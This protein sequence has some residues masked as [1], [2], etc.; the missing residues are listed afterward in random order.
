MWKMFSPHVLL[1]AP[2]AQLE[3]VQLLLTSFPS[4]PRIWGGVTSAAADSKPQPM[5]SKSTTP[6][7]ASKGEKQRNNSEHKSADGAVS[8]SAVKNALSA[9]TS[10]FGCAPTT[11]FG[12]LLQLMV[13]HR[14]QAAS[15]SSDQSV[16]SNLSSSLHSF[17]ARV[18]RTSGVFAADV[19]CMLSKDADSSTL[20]DTVITTWLRH[21][22]LFAV[23]FVEKV[24]TSRLK[25]LT[26]A[27]QRATDATAEGKAFPLLMFSFQIVTTG[28]APVAPITAS[29]AGLSN[30]MDQAVQHLLV[31]VSSDLAWLSSPS[32]ASTLLASVGVALDELISTREAS[33]SAVAP[34]NDRYA[35]LRD[36]TAAAGAGTV[37]GNQ[38]SFEQRLKAL[39]D[40]TAD[41]SPVAA[42][43]ARKSDKAVSVPA[44]PVNSVAV[45]D[46]GSY[47]GIVD[48][49]KQ[50]QQTCTLVQAVLDAV[51]AVLLSIGNT[52]DSPVQFAKLWSAVQAQSRPATT[53][54]LSSAAL[55]YSN[56]RG[57]S[58][59]LKSM[60]L[61]A[62]SVAANPAAAATLKRK[63]P[64]ESGGPSHDAA[65]EEAF[66]HLPLPAIL[67]LLFG[68]PSPG[69]VTS[70]A[71]QPLNIDLVHE[72]VQ[73]C[74]KM[75]YATGASSIAST[76]LRQELL[77]AVGMLKQVAYQVSCIFLVKRLSAA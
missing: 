44:G 1:L 52:R 50:Q 7:K 30:A 64:A 74:L 77:S 60:L 31:S 23:P 14:D 67:A 43:K 11:N 66:K 54:L 57:L 58:D 48:S 13:L 68:W 42:K 18:L 20:T 4:D 8:V 72:V 65:S 53:A 6:S 62:P 75:R 46:A 59:A 2:A 41:S 55:A 56:L 27:Q 15:V 63:Q 35:M 69:V 38:S 61:A 10:L 12:L 3:L 26:S 29:P 47:G 36:F 16:S 32:V 21:V 28:K 34:S 40:L 71:A 76:I 19:A 73:R 24:I 39:M 25:H 5:D 45:G 51:A 37:Q 17:L 33:S 22:T 70:S 9:I 49:M